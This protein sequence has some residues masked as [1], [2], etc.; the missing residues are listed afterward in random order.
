MSAT[1]LDASRGT[2]NQIAWLDGYDTVSATS[3]A[4]GSLQLTTDIH[5]EARELY[6]GASHPLPFDIFASRFDCAFSPF[7]FKFVMCA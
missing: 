1:R 5:N 4:V 6:T 7:P 2:G 3:L